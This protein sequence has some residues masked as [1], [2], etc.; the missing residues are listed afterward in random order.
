MLILGLNMFHPD[1]SAAVMQDG[2]V[3]FAI[4]EE[5][6]N[7]VKHYG[8]IPLLSIKACLDA[9]GARITDVDHVAIGR[10]NDANLIKK[11]RFALSNASQLVNLIKVRKRGNQMRDLKALIARAAD[12]DPRTFRFKEHHVE[13]HLAHVASAFYCSPWETAAG[14]SYDG[15]GDFVTTMLTRCEGTEI[16]VLDRVFVPHSLGHFYAMICDF[17]GYRKYGDEGKIMGLAPYGKDTFCEQLSRIVFPEGNTFRLDLSYFLPFGAA[18]MTIGEDGRVA[19]RRHYSDRMK[20]LFGEPS[21]PNSEITQREMDLAYAMQRRFEEI[22]FDLLRGL[23]TRVPC[24]DLVMAGG[25]A[26]NSVANGKTFAETP[27]RRTWIQPAA[28]DEGLAVGAALYAYHSILKQP[29]RYVM[30]NA[31]W[32]G[33]LRARLRQAL[34]AAGLKYRRLEREPLLDAVAAR[35]SEGDVV[36]WFQGRMEWGPRWAIGRS[37]LIRAAPR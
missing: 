3:V 20:E 17:I 22:Y 12:A 5:R 30:R 32:T 2:E 4:A 14:L 31:S 8:G 33:I 35:I 19:L 25:C 1:A 10:G 29:R 28:G 15:S 34:D 21:E 26:L 9:V 16:E 36:G 23:H 24:D 37:W 7:R 6:L 13:H 27:F 11:V 18:G